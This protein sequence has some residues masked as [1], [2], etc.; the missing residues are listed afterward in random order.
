MWQWRGGE[1][2]A[3]R[4]L[5]VL[6]VDT[7]GQAAALRVM[8]ASGAKQARR[9]GRE[10]HEGTP[11][12]CAA[13]P[14][15]PCHPLRAATQPQRLAN[16]ARPP[17]ASSSV[18]QRSSVPPC[19]LHTSTPAQ[20]LC[21]SRRHPSPP[22]P[23]PS[24]CAARSSRSRA[25]PPAPRPPPQPPR[26]CPP[27][28]GGVGLRGGRRGGSEEGI[29]SRRASGRR[30]GGCTAG[31]RGRPAG[32]AARIRSGSR[33][34]CCPAGG[35][36]SPRAGFCPPALPSQP[37]ARNSRAAGCAPAPVSFSGAS[38]APL[39]TWVRLS[40]SGAY[41]ASY[42]SSSARRSSLRRSGAIEEVQGSGAGAK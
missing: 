8:S 1:A 13:R 31:G 29:L 34:P 33:R 10:G 3:G 37:A 32:A 21:P 27:L 12:C 19:P 28:G 40:Y 4:H 42:F 6:A 36:A 2:G 5:R 25:R 23:P 26:P 18:A 17:A 15:A 11:R 38:A 9:R 39:T 22:S 30:L 20:R 16:A 24:R 41:S 7:A 35:R 14:A